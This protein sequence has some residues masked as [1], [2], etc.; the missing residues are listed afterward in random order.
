M[1]RPLWPSCRSRVSLADLPNTGVEADTG[2]FGHYGTGGCERQPYFQGAPVAM[3]DWWWPICQLQGFKMVSF[4]CQ[5]KCHMLGCLGHFSVLVI[6][7]ANLVCTSSKAWARR[8]HLLIHRCGW[9][10]SRHENVTPSRIG[11][12]DVFPCFT[13]DLKTKIL[14]L[15]LRK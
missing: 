4:S 11:D 10:Q 9:Q 8:A 1:T 3:G 5:L 7:L 15:D 2:H 6:F 12:G 13:L 14:Q